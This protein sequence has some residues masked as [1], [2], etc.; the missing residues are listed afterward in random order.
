MKGTMPLSRM[1]TMPCSKPHTPSTPA[2]APPRSGSRASE[3]DAMNAASRPAQG[4]LA[5]LRSM[6]GLQCPSSAGWTPV[7]DS[8]SRSVPVLRVL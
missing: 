7:K 4:E 2:V 8:H 5:D 6:G 3:P 1:T